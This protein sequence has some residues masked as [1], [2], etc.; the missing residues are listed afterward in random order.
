MT[1]PM[2]VDDSPAPVAPGNAM[3][4]L[5][6]GARAAKGKGKEVSVADAREGLPW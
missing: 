1:E 3:A 2:D 6:A 5:M 4:A